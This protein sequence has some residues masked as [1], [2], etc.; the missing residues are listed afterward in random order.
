MRAELRRIARWRRTIPFIISIPAFIM[1]GFIFP[2]ISAAF[3]MSMFAMSGMPP[4]PLGPAPPPPPP[5]PPPMPGTPPI[6]CAIRVMF[7]IICGSMFFI[8]P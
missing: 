3:D 5:P 7:F 2:I 6:C 4:A 8:I 1:S